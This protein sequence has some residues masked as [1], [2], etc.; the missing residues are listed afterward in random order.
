MNNN[1]VIYTAL[2]GN[3]DNLMDP[4]EDYEGCDFICFTDQK[5]LHSNI[6]NIVV[7]DE[8]DLAPNM[9]NRRY[10]ILPHLFLEKYN[11]SLY[12]DSNIKIIKN[13]KILIEK[14]L[15]DTKIALPRHFARNCLYDEA[16]K[17]VEDKK[18]AEEDV[19]KQI[20]FYKKENFP[21]NFG[22]AENNIIF[23][24]HNDKEIVVLMQEW[25]QLLNRYTQRDQLSLMYLLWK[26]KVKFSLMQESARGSDY[27]RIQIHL[28]RYKKKTLLAT[29]INSKN[30]YILNHPNGV[31]SFLNK[32]IFRMKNLLKKYI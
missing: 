4:C 1:F 30:E 7:I 23:R 21:P 25:W 11:I 15:K 32:Q 14:Y 5:D 13:P 9:M 31:V 16:V 20:D 28:D 6:W 17:V 2:F 3:Y 27:F 22:L 19:D 24:E 29:L 12:V 26:H 8:I 18:A 10:K